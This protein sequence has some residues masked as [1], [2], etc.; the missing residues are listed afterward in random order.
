MKIKGLGSAE[1]SRGAQPAPGSTPGED[2]PR[3]KGVS[4]GALE[5]AR[6]LIWLH[7]RRL[8]IGLTLMLVNRLSGLVLPT[9]TKYLMDNVILRN[10]WDLLPTL[11]LAVAGATLVESVTSFSL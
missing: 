3:K 10:Q 6:A 9:T 1:R 2:P 11:A 7:R 5:E 8:A 4:P